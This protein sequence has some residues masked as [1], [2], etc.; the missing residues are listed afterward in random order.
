MNVLL[1][2][3]CDKRALTETRRILD[4]F[5]ERRGDRTWQTPITQAGLDTLRKLLRRTARKNTAV[6]CHWIRGVDHSELV[7]IVGDARRFNPEGAVPTNTTSRDVLRK[8]DENDWHTLPLIRLLAQLAALMH[9]LGKSIVAFQNMLKGE[10]N[11]RNLYRHEWV[12]LRLFQAFVGNGDDAEWL[13]RL[14]HPESWSEADWLGKDRF[15]RDGIDAAAEDNRPFAH[16][17]PVARAVGWLIVTHHRLPVVP[18]FHTNGEQDWLGRRPHNWDPRYLDTPLDLIAHDWNERRPPK[19]T[20]ADEIDKYWTMVDTLPVMNER[21]QG[22][23]ARIAAH[24]LKRLDHGA[25]EALSNPYVMHL[26]RLSLMLA[27]HYYSSLGHHKDRVKSDSKSPIYANTWS[28]HEMGKREPT[29]SPRQPLD[30]HLMGVGHETGRI[31]CALPG[32]ERYLPCLT[33]IRTLQK[34]SKNPR[35][36]W[37][38]KA[39]DAARGIAEKAR[40]RGAFIINMASTGCGKTLGNARIL[41]ALAPDKRLRMTYALGLRTLTMQTGRIYENNLEL[42]PETEVA[43]LVGGHANR[44]LFE[45]HERDA[46][47]TGS[48]STQ[49]LLEEDS[50]VFY[51]GAEADHP[52]LSRAMADR[53]IKKLLS[54]PILVTTV[55]HIVPATESLR[56]GRQIA[57]MLRLMSSDLVLDELDDYALEDMPAITRLVYW[58]GLLG[59]RVLLSSATLPPALVTGIFLAYRAGRKQYLR[60]RGMQGS[61][62]KPEPEIPCLWADEFGCQTE[63]CLGGQAFREAHQHFV[64][65]RVCKLAAVPDLRRAVIRPF[66]PSGSKPDDRYTAFA[67]AAQQASF[68]LHAGHHDID[69]KTRHAVSFGLV[70]MANIRALFRVAQEFMA[71][72]VP[73][74]TRLHVCVY[75]SRF[76]LIQRAEIE[77]MLDGVFTRKPDTRDNDPVWNHPEVRNRLDAYAEPNQI[78]IV[79]ASPVCEVGRDWDADWAVVEPSS[80]GSI[81]QLAGR[82]QRH[83]QQPCTTPNMVIFNRNLRSFEGNGGVAFE[84]PGYESKQYPLHSHDLQTLLSPDDL[85]PI[86]ARLRIVEPGDLGQEAMQASLIALEQGRVRK[87]LIPDRHFNPEKTPERD[88][89]WLSWK[90][91]GSLLTGLAPQ[92]QPFRE[93]RLKEVQLA[94]LPDE[95]ETALLLHRIEKQ[96]DRRGTDLYTCVDRAECKRLGLNQADRADTWQP[97]DTLIDLLVRM[98]EDRNVSLDTAAR[99]FATLQAPESGAGWYWHPFLGLTT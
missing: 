66:A 82:V 32:F 11:G 28:G 84:W 38:D 61:E 12:S 86:T 48:A 40:D 42:E 89:A 72:E 6:A 56:G 25:T 27:D 92:Y 8:G 68:Q 37:Q 98:A 83:R 46:A 80:V 76:P 74:D 97:T 62:A 44:D 7:W 35:F 79:L 17:P 33:R 41:Y 45:Y 29:G 90:Q 63:T 77:H 51:E 26:A 53:A 55:D 96:H 69:P 60:N 3:Q 93:T 70:R 36:R 59:T 73:K 16:L 14:T 47:A 71:L 54:A 81:I 87:S 1:V 10:Q 64:D 24:L 58:A 67:E 13:G 91:M 30:E 4:Q 34:R 88:T 57:P 39:F 5:A 94:F 19:G 22:K 23:A 2:S 20:Q 15:L 21:W 49:N 50:H 31:A 78:F 43:T 95:D 9:D 85:A 99:H 75:H 18:V 52:M 65:Q